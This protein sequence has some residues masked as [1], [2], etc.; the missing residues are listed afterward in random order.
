MQE[1]ELATYFERLSLGPD[2]SQELVQMI[3]TSPARKVGQ[4]ALDNVTVRFQSI[5]NHS[6]RCLESH[7]VERLF[8]YELE[9]DPGV[10][11]FY[12][13]VACHGI[14]RL[15]D[16]GN[17]RPKRHVSSATLDFLVLHDTHI[18]LVECKP[19]Q[20][21]NL[22]AQ[23][24]PAEWLLRDGIVHRP[25]LSRWANERGLGYRVWSPPLPVAVYLANLELMYA[26]RQVW[27]RFEKIT[28]WQ[29]AVK[30]VQEEPRTIADLCESFDW[31]TPQTA[32]LLLSQGVVFGPIR[33][34][35]FDE[36]DRFKLYADREQ[37]YLSEL[38][39]LERIAQSQSQSEDPVIRASYTDLI[40]GRKRLARVQR[41]LDG[42]ESQTRRMAPL[43]AAV[44]AARAAGRND[45]APCLTSYS[46][47]GNRLPRLS[48]KQICALEQI[49][50]RWNAGNVH[51]RKDLHCEL[52][53]ICDSLGIQTPSETTLNRTIAKQPSLKRI[54]NT[55]GIRLYQRS[56]PA[57]DVRLR[58]MGSLAKRL[59]LEIDSTKF[60]NRVT[61]DIVGKLLF[62]APTV[63]AGIDGSTLDPMAHSFVFGPARR[64]GLALLIRDYRARHG[65]LP[66]IIK[67][68]R[69]PE[70]RSDW[71]A[72]FC[73]RYNITLLHDP[74][75]GSRG[76]GGIENLLGRLNSSLAHRLPG[77][78]APDQA[79]R[80]V[81]G[82]FK[83]Y[84]TARMQFEMVRAE[85][86]VLLYRDFAD[87]PGSDG[88]S[89]AERGSVSSSYFCSIGLSCAMDDEFFYQT[90][91]PVKAQELS[92][93][94]GIR[95][96]SQTFCSA[97]LL[98]LPHSTEVKDV[99]RDCSD[100]SL[101]WV[102]LS[103]G[104]VKAWSRLTHRFAAASTEDREFHTFYS[105][106]LREEGRER[107][108][109]IRLERY[110]RLEQMRNQSSEP[111]VEVT[112]S[113]PHVPAPH[114]ENTSARDLA[115]PEEVLDG[116]SEIV[117]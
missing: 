102:Q 30:R 58:S 57:S 86:E 53:L 87:T 64:A 10:R 5:K 6:V 16:T 80:Q 117:E 8:A 76:K 49:I 50:E 98:A 69:G 2:Q 99:R 11:A 25:A 65:R 67:M 74:T 55:G 68:D 19:S 75:A 61:P 26:L 108:S 33:A 22:L 38:H 31:F 3:R 106:A 79:G 28:H 112:T 40:Q 41:I 34:I 37:A 35:P 104:A 59:I 36:I 113:G 24:K 21:V 72:G 45:L 51:D 105:A 116:Y 12:T 88:V 107:K 60:D 83:S 93:I 63:Y 15:I 77:S 43:V 73:D 115:L 44:L 100:P 81:D 1:L 42:K 94:K 89:P 70:N 78:T 92:F 20:R 95:T 62:D 32:V 71:M 18:E 48:P 111:V 103:R 114:Y 4:A 27:G 9:L 109:Q 97:E 39:L 14:E 46:S 90:S 84:R 52:R 56:K 47:S 91:I 96:N 110:M 17:G 23:R 54:L 101:L 29:C 7:T 82:R 13:Q 66:H 85:L